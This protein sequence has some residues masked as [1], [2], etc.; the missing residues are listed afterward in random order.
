MENF[1]TLIFSFYFL[2]IYFFIF[3]YLFFL[4]IFVS[5]SVPVWGLI[6]PDEKGSR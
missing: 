6:K 2:K 1:D 5:D 4:S 3:A